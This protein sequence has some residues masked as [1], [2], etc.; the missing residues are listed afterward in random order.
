MLAAPIG[1]TECAG[2]FFVIFLFFISI[3]SVRLYGTERQS[4]WSILRVASLWLI[5]GLAKRR[6][7]I[8]ILL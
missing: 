5:A 7:S 4:S 8:S 3:N 2:R 1:F 6:L